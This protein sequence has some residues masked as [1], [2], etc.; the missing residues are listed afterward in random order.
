[1]VLSQFRS[2]ICQ[3]F[4]GHASFCRQPAELNLVPIQL[5]SE[6]A[7]IGLQLVQFAA[8]YLVLPL[9]PGHFHP[10]SF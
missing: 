4:S 7:V 5:Q 1:M 6:A 2:D 9:Q 3:L 8:V 10:E